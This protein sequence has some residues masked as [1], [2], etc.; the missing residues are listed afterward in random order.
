MA[1]PDYVGSLLRINN[2]VK[3]VSLKHIIRI[4]TVLM[5]DGNDNEVEGNW[6]NSAL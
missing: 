3:D 4:H 2:A 6:Q 5:I 1:D